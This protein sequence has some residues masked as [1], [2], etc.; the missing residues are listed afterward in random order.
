MSDN[1]MGIWSSLVRLAGISGGMGPVATNI[2]AIHT[3][4]FSLTMKLVPAA[5]GEQNAGVEAR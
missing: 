3:H 1:V 2:P 5:K 4:P